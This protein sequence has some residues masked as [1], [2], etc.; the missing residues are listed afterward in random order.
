MDYVHK[1][2]YIIQTAD[3]RYSGNAG[4]YM[5][6]VLSSNTDTSQALEVDR[7]GCKISLRACYLTSL[8]ISYSHVK[9]D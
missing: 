2:V 9:V 8:S 5:P 4:C 7:H 1:Q 3:S 6:A